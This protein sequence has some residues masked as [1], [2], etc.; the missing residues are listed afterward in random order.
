MIRV[1]RTVEG[2]RSAAEVFAYLADFTTTT[3]WDPGSVRTV[4]ISGD[5]GVGTKY[6]NT[7]RFNGR[8]TELVYEVID[9][10]AGERV[11]L[12]GT[13]ATVIAFDTITVQALDAGCRVTYDAQFTFRGVAALVAPL[14][15]P[16]FRRLADEAE[17]GLRRVVGAA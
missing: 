1:V 3:E 10:V 7:S 4:R 17:T 12:R 9:F 15:R 14:L 11:Q 6:H 13:N 5:G 8:E 16:A 2:P